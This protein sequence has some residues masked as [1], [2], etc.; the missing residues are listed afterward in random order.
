MSGCG[1]RPAW[2]IAALALVIAACGGGG[3]SGSGPIGGPPNPNPPPNLA[4]IVASPNTERIFVQNHPFEVDVTKGG[5]VFVDP[6]GDTLTYRVEIHNGPFGMVVS[7]TRIMGPGIEPGFVI[8][9]VWASDGQNAPVL[10]GFQITI[11][12]NSPPIVVN[13]NP[14]LLVSAGELIQHD[15][16]QDGST[17]AD[18][19]GDPLT[20]EVSIRGASHALT[21]TDT[22]VNGTMPGVGSARVKI[23]AS[24]G[25][26]AV[27]AN[28]FSIAVPAAE[29][30]R[31]SLPAISHLYSDED[32]ALPFLF[33]ELAEPDHP[34][35]L[36]T[37]PEDNPTTDAGATLG[38]VLF[39]DKRL[40]I[41][42]T[43][44]CG[45]CH[46]QGRGFG[47]SDRFSLGALGL[48]LPRH[49]MALAN[50][51]YNT[52]NEYFSDMRIRTLEN[53]ALMPIEEPLELGNP[54]PLVEEKLRAVDFYP[55]LF[56][57]AFGTA[58]IDSNRIARA[59]AQFLRSM[60]SYRSKFD[61][62]FNPMDPGVPVDPAT[63]L[64]AQE[65]RGR[66]VYIDGACFHC[67]TLDVH[68]NPF[69]ANNGLDETITDPGTADGLGEF[70]AAAL[71]NIAVSGPYMHD[72][73]FATLRDVIEHYDNG[74][75]MNPGLHIFFHST[76]CCGPK[77]M[78]LSTADKD[79][80]EAFLN[81]FTDEEFLA[82][83]KFSDP[84][85]Q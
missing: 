15:A 58:E 79:A 52:P 12:A 18:A 14:H 77:R 60:M 35:F 26:G 85:A 78:N 66:Q 48:P 10:D 45:S 46:E 67:H 56:E 68:S 30:G 33:R 57:A 62:A 25:F 34:F 61:R 47:S 42:N 29:P 80:L 39:Y 2:G 63:V 76:T 73:R 53:L 20:Y 24:D 13:P 65:L 74:I 71:R 54:L 5:T 81:T 43:H 19:D 44:S 51:R 38:R 11:L 70:R 23:T 50:S 7:G 27:G 22:H 49:A 4:P 64:T 3:D 75:K 82:D 55:P 37:M 32:L 16:T 6:D 84:F 9:D 31:P 8:V 36:D 17:F 1:L 69:P 28:E 72:G 21:T 83:P 41:T 40:S 59:L